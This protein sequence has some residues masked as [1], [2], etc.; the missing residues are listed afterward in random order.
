[1]RRLYIV[2][3]PVASTTQPTASTIAGYF[4][5]LRIIIGVQRAEAMYR[6]CLAV[7]P[8]H[9]YALYNLAVLK[10]ETTRNGD[11]SEVGRT[12]CAGV[13]FFSRGRTVSVSWLTMTVGSLKHLHTLFSLWWAQGRVRKGESLNPDL[14]RLWMAAPVFCS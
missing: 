8:E 4:Y 9:S 2:H 11:Y 6:R 13:V 7:N 5:V 14:H 12:N 10:E 1:M 3:D